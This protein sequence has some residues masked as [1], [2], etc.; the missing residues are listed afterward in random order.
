MKKRKKKKFI[1]TGAFCVYILLCQDGTYYTGHTNDLKRR[2]KQHSSGKGAWYTRVKGA[3]SVVW[4][5]EY[6]RFKPAFLMENR[7]KKL[8]RLQKESLV[9]GKRLD[10]VLAKAGNKRCETRR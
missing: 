4:R 1:R 6:R 10:K 5:K 7:I 3:G 8:T 2:L 9:G